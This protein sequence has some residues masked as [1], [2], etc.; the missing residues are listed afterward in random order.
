[1]FNLSL[2]IADQ[3]RPYVSKAPIGRLRARRAFR[4]SLIATAGMAI[5]AAVAVGQGDPANMLWTTGAYLYGTVLMGILVRVG[6]LI[7]PLVFFGMQAFFAP[8]LVIVGVVGAVRGVLHGW[9]WLIPIAGVVMW[10][11]VF[12]ALW[13][14]ILLLGEHV[15]HEADRKRRLK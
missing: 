11:G 9:G 8:A 13:N 15:Q 10:V 3:Q 1:M 6:W 5:F 12:G 14:V 4:Y 7:L 2:R